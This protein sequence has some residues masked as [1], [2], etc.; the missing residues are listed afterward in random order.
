MRKGENKRAVPV[1]VERGLKDNDLITW[2][3]QRLR[4]REDSFCCSDGCGDLREGIKSDSHQ[5][6]IVVGNGIDQTQVSAGTCV[7]ILV[8]I[9]SGVQRFFDKVGGRP[10]LFLC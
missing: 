2:V 3:E 7:L 10:V 4:A 9:D 1:D 6:R 8:R 5:R